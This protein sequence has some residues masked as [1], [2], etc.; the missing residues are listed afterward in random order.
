VIYVLVAFDLTEVL[1]K[2][3]LLIALVWASVVT[4][5]LGQALAKE[6]GA[7]ALAIQDRTFDFKPIS[8]SISGIEAY[9]AVA[10]FLLTIAYLDSYHRSRAP[11]RRASST[12][13]APPAR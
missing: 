6:L 1:G 9:F 12:S 7:I 4:V 2:A 5:W 10:Y 11:L 8:A 13:A 3:T